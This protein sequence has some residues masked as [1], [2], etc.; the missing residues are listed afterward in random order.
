MWWLESNLH[1]VL[2]TQY[3]LNSVLVAYYLKGMNRKPGRSSKF[4]NTYNSPITGS[5]SPPPLQMP[6]TYNC[7]HNKG[8]ISLYSLSSI[9]SFPLDCFII[10]GC[11]KLYTRFIMNGKL[12]VS[13]LN[14]IA[15]LSNILQ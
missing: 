10:H 15:I 4:P 3:I 5:Q 13:W 12:H 7:N 9:I 14:S 1:L 11:L 6:T 2:F 8:L